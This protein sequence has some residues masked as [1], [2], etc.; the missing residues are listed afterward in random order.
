MVRMAGMRKTAWFSWMLSAG[1]MLAVHGMAVAQTSA[2]PMGEWVM[3]IGRRTL[4][5]LSI[6]PAE[7]AG[8]ACAGSLSRPQRVQTADAVSFS[9]INGPIEAE[10]IV[11]C[12]RNGDILTITV[13]HPADRS[14]RDAYRL[15][16]RDSTHAVLQLQ[17]V[18]LAPFRLERAKGAVSVSTDWD[19]DKTYSPDVDVPSNEEMKR[20][21]D[22]DQ[23]AREAG[24][25]T[26]WKEVNRTDAERRDATR[27]LLSDGALHT[28]EDF[29]RAAF[30]FQHGSTPD[31]YLLAH[32]LAIVAL[33]K[34]NQ[35]GAWIAAATLDRYL[36]T[37]NQPQIYG[38]QFRY[39]K[40][41]ATTQDPYNRT[42]ISDPLRQQLGVPS[43]DQQ[44]VQLKRFDRE[45][46]KQ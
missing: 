3:Q 17:G 25:K 15:A 33:K 1:A 40:G 12:E 34:G 19:A 39:P 31:D 20:I 38:T 6:H 46:P 10:P 36:Q 23:R 5:V 44:T 8:Q 35:D 4:F 13:E 29:W 16:A 11:A 2:D 28:G 7:K 14:D 32:T 18:P 24:S 9:H 42:L 21:F 22:E 27:K 26:D 37:V 45:R 43:I 30:V 41:E